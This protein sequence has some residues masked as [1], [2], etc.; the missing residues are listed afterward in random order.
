MKTVSRSFDC[1]YTVFTYRK[2]TFYCNMYTS[3][4][5]RN[6]NFIIIMLTFSPLY[7]TCIEGRRSSKIK[8]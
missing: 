1:T 2:M 8:I 7:C 6:K 5:L 4:Y 3:L